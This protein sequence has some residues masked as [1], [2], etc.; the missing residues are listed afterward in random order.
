M[1]ELSTRWFGENSKYRLTAD[2]CRQSQL[3]YVSTRLMA[4]SDEVETDDAR[5]ERRAGNCLWFK[6]ND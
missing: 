4:N 3:L 5:S 2:Y 6:V 1:L